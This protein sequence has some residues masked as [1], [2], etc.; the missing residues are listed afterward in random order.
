MR[1]LSKAIC[2]VISCCL[3]MVGCNKDIAPDEMAQTLYNFYVQED[4]TNIEQLGL[5]QEEATDITEGGIESFETELEEGLKDIAG[6]HEVTVQKE[7]VKKAIEARRALEK[8]L[9]SEVEIISKEKNSAQIKLYTTY[10]NEEAIYDRAS[11]E[12][13]TRMEEAQIEEEDAFVQQCIDIYIEEIIKAYESAEI[14][15]DK[16]SILVEFTKQGDKWLP[17]DQ[18][19]FIDQLTNLTSGYDTK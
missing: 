9:T 19:A 7:N 1:K 18:Q 2:V 10:F 3:L 5:T 8:K 12:L 15:T 6:E 11:K 4:M 16:K 14:S 13:E 17:I